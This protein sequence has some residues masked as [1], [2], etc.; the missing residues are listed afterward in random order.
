[1]FRQVRAGPFPDSS[2]LTLTG[3]TVAV[4][5]HGRGVPMVEANIGP[6]KIDEEIVI[7]RRLLTDR[8]LPAGW[9][10]FLDTVIHKMS[11]MPLSYS[12]RL[13]T[14]AADESLP[15]DCRNCPSKLVLSL[16]LSHVVHIGVDAPRLFK[17]RDPPT[18][19]RSTASQLIV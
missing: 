13:K 15:V 7:S 1:M 18:H 12:T 5:C 16:R 6:C 17:R 10:G 2:H 11:G 4:R 19:P 3:K 8:G 9:W 14:D